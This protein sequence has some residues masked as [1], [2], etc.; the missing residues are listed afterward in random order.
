MSEFVT[1]TLFPHGRER[2]ASLVALQAETRRASL[3]SWLH[4]SMYDPYAIYWNRVEVDDPLAVV[5]VLHRVDWEH[6]PLLV[7]RSVTDD[8]WSFLRIVHRTG[9]LW[10]D[11]E[12]G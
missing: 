5:N 8:S 6:A 9:S 1:Y 10:G 12:R 4:T 7:Y 3:P 2:E 11:E